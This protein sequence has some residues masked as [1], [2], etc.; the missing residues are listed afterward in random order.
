MIAHSGPDE[1]P[2][3]VHMY[4]TGPDTK[5]R[6]YSGELE[7][8]RAKEAGRIPEATDTLM[9][10]F[11]CIECA[12]EVHGTLGNGTTHGAHS[13]QHDHLKYVSSEAGATTGF[14]HQR[15]QQ[16]R[17][18]PKQGEQVKGQIEQMGGRPRGSPRGA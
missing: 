4:L 17:K 10:R 12:T 11:K 7:R 6:G 9:Q 18:G 15:K 8:Q 1:L 14:W 2:G 13:T 16:V 5:S 3:I